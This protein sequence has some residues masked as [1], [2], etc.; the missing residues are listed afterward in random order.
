VRIEARVNGHAALARGQSIAF[1]NG[2]NLRSLGDEQIA[3][4]MDQDSS[5]SGMIHRAHQRLALWVEVEVPL[6]LE[7]WAEIPDEPA[8]EQR[9]KIAR[10]I[11]ALCAFKPAGAQVAFVEIGVAGPILRNVMPR[12]VEHH[13]WGNT[14]YIVEADEVSRLQIFVDDILRDCRP[15]LSLAKRRLY[16]SSLRPA[17][18]DAIVDAVIGVEALLNTE[19]L[20]EVTMRVA[21]NYASLFDRSE[22]AVRYARIK[23]LYR[24]RSDIVHGRGAPRGADAGTVAQEATALLRELIS[25]FWKDDALRG[26]VP[27]PMK[28]DVAYWEARY[29]AE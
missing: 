12:S 22:R 19:N 16:Q 20:P 7:P 11:E 26:G 13:P 6:R 17:H 5:D 29:F 28:L 1:S 15:E 14:F 2:V 4:E 10:V 27:K 9:A 23:A 21:M 3:Q 25:R 24:A 18:A 8:T